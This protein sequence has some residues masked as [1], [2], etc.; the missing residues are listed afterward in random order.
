LSIP[1]NN[2]ARFAGPIEETFAKILDFYGI[3]WEYEPHTFPLVKDRDGKVLEAF[4]P[5]FYLPQQDLYIELTTLR[6]HLATYK[7]RRMRLMK[8]LY[9][10]IKI[11]LLKRRELRDMMIKYGLVQEA[12]PIQGN[13]AQQVEP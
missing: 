12:I 5:D 6:P 7:N 2:K 8:E 1:E 4:A 13:H 9:P 10:E 3:E 11:K